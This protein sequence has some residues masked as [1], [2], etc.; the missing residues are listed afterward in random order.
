LP[1]F[2]EPILGSPEQ[3]AQF[4]RSDASRW[5]KV[6]REAKLSLD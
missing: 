6:I 3:F 5:G 1:N 2:Y 4:V